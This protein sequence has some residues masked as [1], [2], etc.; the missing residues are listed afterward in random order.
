MPST[1][2][3]K[4]KKLEYM[5][6]LLVANDIQKNMIIIKDKINEA[7]NYYNRLVDFINNTL[8]NE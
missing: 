4:I 3:D 7:I 5:Q 8:D 6:D 1:K 2:Q